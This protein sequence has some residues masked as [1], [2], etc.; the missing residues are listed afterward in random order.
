MV[1]SNTS[2]CYTSMMLVQNQTVPSTYMYKLTVS[3]QQ[4]NRVESLLQMKFRPRGS[5]V[6]LTLLNDELEQFIYRGTENV[7]V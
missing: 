4:S 6:L 2:Y 1:R 7:E 3:S 5:V